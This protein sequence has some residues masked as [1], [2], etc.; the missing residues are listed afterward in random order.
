MASVFRLPALGAAAALAAS[1][2]S[3]GSA[4]A[5]VVT[6][7]GLQYDVTTFTGTYNANASKFSTAAN[8]GVMPWYGS[9]SLAQNFA[10]AVT[11]QLGLFDQRNYQVKSRP[12]LISALLGRRL[13]PAYVGPSAR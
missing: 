12:Q 2:L 6:V 9:A 11:G 1:R 8:G 4:Q 5:Y 3:A 7:G 10:S 13:A